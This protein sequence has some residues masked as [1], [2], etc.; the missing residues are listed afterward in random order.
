M[1]STCAL[2]VL[3]WHDLLLMKCYLK[4]RNICQ[5]SIKAFWNYR[6]KT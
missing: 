4:K 5:I 6:T 1:A 2:G 3:K